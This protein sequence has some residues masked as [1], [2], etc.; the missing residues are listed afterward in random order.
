MNTPAF[1]TLGEAAKATGK[2]KGTIKNAITKGRLSAEKNDKGEYSINVAELHR[3]Y[4]PLTSEQD[5]M[6]AVTPPHNTG[7]TQAENDALR[8]EIELLREM[9]AKADAQTERERENADKWQKQAEILALTD[10]RSK[11]GRGLFGW[12]KKVG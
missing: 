5:N 6:N 9:L 4:K 3:V 7:V 11:Q 8:R 12:L 2:A 10:Q 1:Y